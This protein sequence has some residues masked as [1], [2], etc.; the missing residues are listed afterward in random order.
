MFRAHPNSILCMHLKKNLR[1]ESH[2]LDYEELQFL[3]KS[4]E[5]VEHYLLKVQVNMSLVNLCIFG[6]MLTSQRKEKLTRSI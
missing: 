5:Q 6:V 2:F 3:Q 1:K 4:N